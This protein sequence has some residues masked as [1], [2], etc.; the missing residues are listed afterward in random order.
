MGGHFLK[1]EQVSFDRLSDY[2]AE[3]TAEPDPNTGVVIGDDGAMVIHTRSPLVMA[4]DVIRH[5]RT[6]TEQATA[7]ARPSHASPPPAR[8]GPPRATSRRI[9]AS[10]Q[11]PRVHC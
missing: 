1:E 5:I 3:G 2:A 9:I 6:V 8:A 7:D 4:Q 11:S 10:R